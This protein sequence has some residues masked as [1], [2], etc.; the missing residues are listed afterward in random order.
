MYKKSKITGKRYEY[1]DGL[2]GFK[3]GDELVVNGLV[4]RINDRKW[5]N[6]ELVQIVVQDVRDKKGKKLCNHVHVDPKGNYENRQ[7]QS[8][9]I[10]QN[11]YLGKRI[12]FVARVFH[13]TTKDGDNN[14]GL[15][16]VKVL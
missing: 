3:D 14:I 10:K 1:R 12:T 15:R 16:L 11:D 4:T 7:K 9:I 13:Y 2:E 6:Y 5:N 8:R